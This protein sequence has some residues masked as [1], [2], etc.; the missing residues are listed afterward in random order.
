MSGPIEVEVKPRQHGRDRSTSRSPAPAPT[1]PRRLRSQPCRDEVA[2]GDDRDSVDGVE[3]AVTGTT[4]ARTTT[5]TQ[6]EDVG[7]ARLRLRPHLRLPDPAGLV[8]LDRGRDQGDPPQP[9]LRRQPRTACSSRSSSGA[10]ART[11]STSSSNGGIAPWL[12]MFLFVILFGLSMDYHVF[13]LSRVREA[14][15]R[16]LSTE[17]AVAHGI[18]STAGVVTSAAVVMVGVFSVFATAADH[19]HEGDG[20][21]P[22][23]RRPDRRHDRPRGAPAGDDEAARRA[24][25]GTCRSGSS[26]SPPRA[27]VGS[28]SSGGPRGPG[29]PPRPR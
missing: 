5:G 21:R 29:A 13:I 17:D 8:P 9:A 2:A 28:A 20:H 11:C 3:Y 26:G 10:G 12:P 6:D 1:P 14:Y 18:K 19:R 23:G 24:A 22:R 16:G 15:D 27:R 4:A 7:A 25:T